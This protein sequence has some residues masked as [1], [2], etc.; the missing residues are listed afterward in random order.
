MTKAKARED[1]W[2]T[3]I[4]EGNGLSSALCC[5]QR[6]Q[7]HGPSGVSVVSKAAKSA[8]IRERIQSEPVSLR[9]FAGP[10]GLDWWL[11]GASDQK[12]ETSVQERDGEDILQSLSA[13]DD[14]QHN[15]THDRAAEKDGKMKATFAIGNPG[16]FF[17]KLDLDGSGTVD[18]SELRENFEKSGISMAEVEKRVPAL[19]AKMDKNGDGSISKDEFVA[20]WVDNKLIAAHKRRKAAE[21]KAQEDLDQMQKAAEGITK[22]QL[23]IKKKQAEMDASGGTFAL[24]PDE[25]KKCE[26]EINLLKGDLQRLQKRVS[27]LRENYQDQQNLHDIARDDFRKISHLRVASFTTKT[28]P[29]VQ[30]SNSLQRTDSKDHNSTQQS[31]SSHGGLSRSGSPR[32]K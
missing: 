5:N 4:V 2:W 3:R 9:G 21:A 14:E 13:F 22:I 25:K 31:R 6:A 19:F 26:T 10:L 17:D 23:L 18:I 11:P 29:G 8:V 30:R 15:A 28:S 32:K 1:A 24:N 12:G 27:A 7:G 20:H 16:K